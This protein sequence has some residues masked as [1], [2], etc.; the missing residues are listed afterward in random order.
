[1]LIHEVGI[2]GARILDFD[3]RMA[4]VEVP[5]STTEAAPKV[6]LSFVTKTGGRPVLQSLNTAVEAAGQADIK[7][8][9]R[10]NGAG[11]HPFA[12]WT[13]QQRG[14]PENPVAVP[15]TVELPQGALVEVVAKN[16]S[17]TTAYDA[18]A[19]VI[20]YYLGE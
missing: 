11:R 7:L 2:R 5:A 20:V 3:D 18:T 19:R 12:D 17:S 15:G 1:M 14:A 6:I 4:T 10:V 16:D 13:D 8:R 9:F